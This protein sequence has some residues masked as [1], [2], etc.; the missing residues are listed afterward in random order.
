MI[1]KKQN[2]PF[3][4]LIFTINGKKFKAMASIVY[5]Q[6]TPMVITAAHCVFDWFTQEYCESIYFSK[7]K[8]KIKLNKAFLMRDWIEN[9]TL[10]YDTAC[11]NIE[12]ITDFNLP[13]KV[14]PVFNLRTMQNYIITYQNFGILKT[15]KQCSFKDNINHSSLLGV[16]L[17][18]NTGSSGGP[19]LIQ[20]SNIIYQNSNSS[21]SFEDYKNIIWGPYWGNEIRDLFIS[22]SQNKEINNRISSY[23]FY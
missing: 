9:G 15:T 22:C 12:N 4:K 13:I 6:N 16:N 20:K 19:W 5:Y 17:K 21:F 23:K 18:V 8:R 10:D 2:Y 3:G 14:E 11:L 1:L 7:G